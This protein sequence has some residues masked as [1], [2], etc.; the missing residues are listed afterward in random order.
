MAARANQAKRISLI[1]TLSTVEL[2]RE[3]SVRNTRAPNEAAPRRR[4]GLLFSFFAIYDELPAKYRVRVAGQQRLSKKDVTFPI[5]VLANSFLLRPG[6]R[7]SLAT[8]A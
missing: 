4:R 5:L 8:G 3:W 6:F 2:Y 1:I 7:L